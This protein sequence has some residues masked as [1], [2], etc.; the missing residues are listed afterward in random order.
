MKSNYSPTSVKRLSTAA[1]LASLMMLTMACGLVSRVQSAL[2][3]STTKASGLW[4]DVPAFAGATKVDADLP[5]P[6]KVMVQAMVA[7]A[8]SENKNGKVKDI[9][10]VI[11][12]TDKKPEDVTAFYTK[13][14]MQAQGWTLK[15]QPGCDA[16]SI[17]EAQQMAQGLGGAFCMFGKQTTGDK[18]FTAVFMLISRQEKDTET[19]IYY[20]RLEGEGDGKQ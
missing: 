3:G 10:A 9:E 12:K 16:A 17:P 20:G 1:A 2:G 4:V 5:L 11:F 6:M 13:E 15:D 19:M 18:N 14:L 7:Q 8:N